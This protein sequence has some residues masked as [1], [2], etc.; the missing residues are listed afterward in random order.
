MKSKIIHKRK[1]VLG[2]LLVFLMF[3]TFLYLPAQASD[4][5]EDD[6][7]DDGVEDDIEDKNRREISVEYDDYEAK[8][9]S[10]LSSNGVENS[11]TAEMKS[12]SEGLEYILE[13]EK[14][15]D[16]NE[17]EIEFEITLSKIIEFIDENDNGTYEPL[18]DTVASEYEINSYNPIEYSAEVINN[19]TIHIFSVE[20]SDGI[21]S[22]TMYV[23]EEFAIINDTL[24]TPTELKFDIIIN[25]YTFTEVDS[26]LALKIEIESELEIDYEEDEETE[27]EKDGRTSDEQEIEIDYGNYTG[28]FSWLKTATI[29]DI[30]Y[31]IN[32]TQIETVSEKGIMYLS[33]PHGNEIYHDP[34]VGIEGLIRGWADPTG[35]GFWVNLPNLSQNELLIVSAISFLVI[36]SLVMVF[37]RKQ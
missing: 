7:D 10:E 20:T 30:E 31:A 32:A 15:I 29:D 11:F 22:S 8:I 33:Y 35:T 17:T 1:L 2:G 27:D 25:N 5:E 3:S 4:D 36:I 16:S 19:N 26:Y 14:E 37:R 34:K 18:I 28:F 9:Q 13:F 12:T 6:E 21:F 23:S 24:I